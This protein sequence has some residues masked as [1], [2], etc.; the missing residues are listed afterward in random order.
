MNDIVAAV[1]D[2]NFDVNQRLEHLRRWQNEYFN[3][4]EQ[5]QILLRQLDATKPLD[6]QRGHQISQL[7]KILIL[8]QVREPLEVVLGSDQPGSRLRSIRQNLISQFASLSKMDRLRWL[9]NFLFIMTPDLLKLHQKI[10]EHCALDQQCHFLLSTPSGMGKTTY[11]NWLVALNLPSVEDQGRV[12]PT[13]VKVNVPL[14]C[15][16][17][18]L[19]KRMVLA[20]GVTHLYGDSAEDLLLTLEFYRQKSNIG[21]FIVDDGEHIPYAMMRNYLLD[22]SSGIHGIPII[23]ASTNAA[24]WAGG[25]REIVGRWTDY[26]TLSTY[27]GEHLRNLLVFIEMLLPFTR[28]PVKNSRGLLKRRGELLRASQHMQVVDDGTATQIEEVFP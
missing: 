6:I 27:T 13:V 26:A 5:L 22:I 21:L 9:N 16:L 23:C 14:N 8:K 1:V 2:E 15:K 17:K 18:T 28:T 19:L 12:A 3:E 25:Y 20:C 10:L 24:G 4:D 11:L 7:R